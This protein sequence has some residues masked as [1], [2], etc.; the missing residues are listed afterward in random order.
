MN[1]LVIG[2]GSMGKRRIR[3]LM[4]NGVPSTNI[5]GYD[6]KSERRAEVED[7]YQ[8][9]TTPDF[10]SLKL[11]DFQAVI[12][13]TPPDLHM[14]YALQAAK[15]SIPMF[16]EASV[17]DEGI[18]SLYQLS[19]KNNVLIYPSCTMKYFQGPKLIKELI[20]SNAIGQVYT[21]QYQSGQYLPDWHPW[22]RIQDYYVSNRITGGCRE[23]VPFELVW[24][25]DLF[26]N[27]TELSAIKSKL[28]DINADI[29]D[30][31]L[32]QVKHKSGILGQLLVDV[33]SRVPV[34]AIRITGSEGTIE[35]DDGQKIIRHFTK[36]TNKWQTIKLSLGSVEK[37]YINPEEPYISEIRDFL[38]SVEHKSQ[39]HYTLQDD[40]EMLQILKKAEISSMTGK[41]QSI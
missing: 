17:V 34:R 41:N 25:V 23:I 21:W 40:Y 13:S 12:I 30:V 20:N 5:I 29:D 7:R 8:V 11:N 14:E 10:N 18:E 38:T 36:K 22:E 39:P 26:G 28:S 27:L 31:Y 16:I 2:L 24:L 4:A 3:C 9:D 19:E 32:L 37:E 6:I 15:V 33:V 35:W 1:Y